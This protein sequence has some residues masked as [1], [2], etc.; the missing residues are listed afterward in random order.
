MTRIFATCLL[1]LA[2]AGFSCSDD[3]MQQHNLSETL[4]SGQTPDG[5]LSYL[6]LGDSY[7]IGEAVD[8]DQRFPAQLADTLKKSGIELS[9][10]II[11]QTGWTTS[12]LIGGISGADTDPLYDLVTL[13]IG[14]NNQYRGLDTMQ[15]REEF[16]TLLSQAIEFAGND[17]SRVMVLSIPDY[18]VTPFAENMDPE[19]IAREIDDFNAIKQDETGKRSVKYFDITTISRKAADDLSLIATDGL[20]PSGKMYRQWVNLMFPHTRHILKNQ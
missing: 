16:R 13:L 7:T 4:H 10:K 9:V 17:T 11:A 6:A 18:G 3:A 20:H 5:G 1:I 15:Y 2:F 8:P 19:K 12:Q 14:V